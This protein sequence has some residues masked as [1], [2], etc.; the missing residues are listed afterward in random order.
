MKIEAR[1]YFAALG[2][3]A[4]V[5]AALYAQFR[6]GR[7]R[8][9]EITGTVL[10]IAPQERTAKF[11]F[12]HPKTGRT[13]QLRGEVPSEC[14]IT[15]DAAPASLADVRMGEQATV[16]GLVYRTGRLVAQKVSIHRASSA[17]TRLVADAAIKNAPP[18]DEPATRSANEAALKP[19]AGAPERQ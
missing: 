15:I 12:V 19:L 2:I 9:R 10:E 7:P 16:T 5:A 1:H 11:E 17:S 14:E 4:V 3:L 13:L 18:A 8:A 6:E